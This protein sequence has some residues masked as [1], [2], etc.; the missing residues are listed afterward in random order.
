MSYPAN[1][2]TDPSLAVPFEGKG[3]DPSDRKVNINARD[4]I[5]VCETLVTKKVK[6][7]TAAPV[8]FQ[9]NVNFTGNVNI[10]GN[11]T[12]SVDTLYE[13]ARKQ[14]PN[15]PEVYGTSRSD[16]ARSYVGYPF[17]AGGE[18]GTGMKIEYDSGTNKSS[19]T[20]LDVSLTFD[21][22][23]SASEAGIMD[24][25]ITSAGFVGPFA[26][27]AN[28]WS[29]YGV[30][31]DDENF[32]YQVNGGP[33]VFATLFGFGTNSLFVCRRKSDARLI[34]VKDCRYYDLV[35]PGST[36]FVG[37]NRQPART[38][39]AIYQDKLYATSMLTNVG[40][41][42]Y[43]INK[44]T[45]ERIWTMLYDVPP[46]AGGGIIV[47]PGSAFG[48]VDP[49]PYPGSNYGLGDLNIVVKELS[50]G[51]PSI[52]VGVS[53]FQNA[54]NAEPIWGVYT[55]Q[56]KLIRVDDQGA[57]AV[58]TWAG[59]TC[60][61]NLVAGDTITAGGDPLKDPFR[62]GKTEV[63]IWR[64]STD[65]AFAAAGGVIGKVLDNTG[66][67]PGFRPMG[68]TGPGT[69]N[70]L[71]MPAVHGRSVSSGDLPLTEASFKSLFRTPAPGIGAG[72]RVYQRYAVAQT[73][74]TAGS[75]SQTLPQA[76]INVGS[77]AAFPAAGSLKIQTNLGDQIVTY[78]GTTA[79]T[80]TGCAGG[81]GVI[82]TGSKV[83]AVLPDTAKT[84]TDVLVD[85]N[86]ALPTLVASGPKVVYIWCYL[87]GAEV[88]AVDGAAAPF[89]ADNVG[90]RYMAALPTPYILA[91]A[92]E[93]AALNY[94][95]NSIWAQTPVIDL[96]RNLVYCG[97]GQAHFLPADEE[98]LFQ[99]PAIDFRDRAQAVLT[100]EYRYT[101][102]DATLG[103]AGPFATLDDI[104][105]AKD[106]FCT[107]TRT[108]CLAAAAMSPR[109]RRCYSDAI[110]GF[111][112]TTGAI[113]FGVR[114]LPSD[115]A[116]FNNHPTI[117]FGTSLIGPDGDNS[118][119]IQLFESVRK[120]DG[121][122]GQFL[123]SCNKAGIICN[124]DISGLNRA[125]PWDH[126]NAITKGL[127]PAYAYGGALSALGGSNYGSCQSGGQYLIYMAHNMSTDV[128]FGGF[129]GS[130]V[131]SNLYTTNSSQGWEFHVTR[132]GRVFQIRDSVLAAYDVGRGEIAW[133]VNIG[134]LSFGYP[135]CYNGVVMMC[136]TE[137]LLVGYDVNDGHKIFSR[138]TASYGVGGITP[139]VFDAG[140]G[141]LVSNYVGTGHGRLGNKGLVLKVSADKIIKSTDTLQTLLAGKNF[142]SYDVI[143]KKAPLNPQAFPLIEP[144][145]ITHSWTQN[146]CAAVH[147]PDGGPPSAVSVTAEAYLTA[148]RIVTFVNG[149]AISSVLRYKYI[150]MLNTT[151][152]ILY[153]QRLQGGVWVDHRATF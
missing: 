75:N 54:I 115:I 147:T 46:A 34:W 125:V 122:I 128:D 149:G 29:W 148:G 95:G 61:Q 116:N 53:S 38:A 138:N 97:T 103:G 39:L 40:P 117:I 132:D 145:V 2:L 96:N 146:V 84:I 33:S 134:Q 4:G 85:L 45:G 113:E 28:N 90:T 62:P 1:S 106:T 69:A 81:T 3:L 43:C 72:A 63:L 79:T 49:S 18:Y 88:T 70:N 13:N 105:T 98:L 16:Q 56:G 118:S 22:V 51:V 15:S 20:G 36:N 44:N 111:D 7:P 142:T 121:K 35:T 91:N 135:M 5:I 55:D 119:G 37:S 102:D 52:F 150:E 25:E 114:T 112:L 153:Y 71:T 83:F 89:L 133:E 110:M 130:G 10:E 109:G 127:N 74:V 19:I 137:G 87:T 100:A 144:E 14:N 136:T 59:A 82:T 32:Y 57:T 21:L 11:V 41:Q 66:P 64:D 31:C 93:A 92:Q 78:T 30:T 108:L 143:P 131:K 107:T 65:G 12:Q 86:A 120:A 50:P 48:S 23:P 76:T 24:S 126:N 58:R 68:Y 141:Y 123:S 47:T 17:Q 9:S 124:I 99:D 27:R 8:E 77:T 26:S 140:V 80:F 73:T 6:S 129:G 152:Y 151:G 94:Y 101:Q 67:H 104:N 42:L 60:V 139:P